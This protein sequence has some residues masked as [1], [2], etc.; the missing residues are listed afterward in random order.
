MEDDIRVQ[1]TTFIM[2]NKVT[3]KI[4]SKVG[5]LQLFASVPHF[6]NAPSDGQALLAMWNLSTAFKWLI[7]PF[8]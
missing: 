1:I 5:T 7:K 4:Q 8:S 6:K 2:N 3:V